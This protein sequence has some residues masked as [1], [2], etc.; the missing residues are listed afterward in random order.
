MRLP[1][2]L[3]FILCLLTPWQST[4][5]EET[6][7]YFHPV[8][9]PVIANNPA[10]TRGAIRAL[11]VGL[12]RYQHA[13]F[14]ELPFARRDAEAF[15]AFLK[16]PYG[17]SLTSEDLVLLADETAT[18]AG[19]T[20]A[21][22]WLLSESRK[23]DKIVVYYA[24]GAQLKEQGPARLLFFDSPPAPTDAGY[25]SLEKLSGLLGE[26]AREKGA[27]VLFCVEFRPILERR[28]Y[29]GS[30][31]GAEKRN[32]LRFEKLG[33]AKPDG[34][35]KTPDSTTPNNSYGRALLGGLLG[36]ADAD[37][38]Q[39]VLGP[40]LTQYLKQW[41]KERP[42][43]GNFAC[44]AFPYNDDWICKA[45]ENARLTLGRQMESLFTPILQLE[46]QPL[47]QFMVTH[48]DSLTRHLYEDFILTIR[49]GQLL[50]PPERCA[51]GLLDSLLRRPELNAVHKQLQRRMAVAYQ[52]DT[53]QALNAYLQT[54][55]KELVRR[56]KNRDHY[57]LYAQYL[58][59]TIDILGNSHFMAKLLEAK[60]L[61]FEGLVLRL[62]YERRPDAAL[63]QEALEK[64]RRA[65]EFEPEAA[66][67]YN[68]MGVVR[69][70]MQEYLTAD[71]LFRI[72]SEYSP[73]WS[74][75]YSNRS[76]TMLRMNRI[77]DALELGITAVSLGHWSPHTYLTLGEVYH[78]KGELDVAENMY[79]RALLIDPESP[80]AWYNLAC[81]ASLKG[82]RDE[83]L[84]S[85]RKALEYGFD[86]P[87]RLRD[88]QDLKAIREMPAFREMVAQYFPAHRKE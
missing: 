12:S 47:D 49:L 39:R 41:E 23:G 44:L 53:Q 87:E 79:R 82:Q 75:P 50:S 37:D 13:G 2:C 31:G 46:V 59:R 26:A 56:R 88:D 86:R 3:P 45:R 19:F 70:L 81:A 54:S 9:S 22:D 72:A 61:Y 42:S 18:L 58:K 27:R 65:I 32:G 69:G 71:S 84:A 24:G 11:V 51:A 83:A 73:T 35:E 68:E 52:D 33:Q 38:N 4:A 76:H 14:T 55:A 28:P 66:F 85:L 78:K 17:G 7:R 8:L 80:L 6:I 10:G 63:L 1:P 30:W 25:F 40:E 64:Q 43:T 74:V 15:A 34:R 77:D 16:T 21:L 5:Q 67:V 60:M 36:M 48:A 57:K 20:D 29:S 62:E